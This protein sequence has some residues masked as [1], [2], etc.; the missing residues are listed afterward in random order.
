MMSRTT[1]VRLKAY[2]DKVSCRAPASAEPGKEPAAGGIHGGADVSHKWSA[3]A[4][5]DI[6]DNVLGRVL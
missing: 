3:E 4:C 1:S 6:D 2:T 5:V